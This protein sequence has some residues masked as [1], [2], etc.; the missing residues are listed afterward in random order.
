MLSAIKNF[1]YTAKPDE[2][3]MTETSFS[4]SVKNDTPFFRNT[5]FLKFARD[6][7]LDHRNS[8]KRDSA[9]NRLLLNTNLVERSE[10]TDKDSDVKNYEHTITLLF[11]TP[12][13]PSESDADV[14]ESDI[15]DA[16]D[17]WR[18]THLLTFEMENFGSMI[19]AFIEAYG[20]EPQLGL[21]SDFVSF[22][23]YLFVH[24]QRV[25]E[26]NFETSISYFN[27]MTFSERNRNN[28]KMYSKLYD[29]HFNVSSGLDRDICIEALQSIIEFCNINSTPS[30]FSQMYNVLSH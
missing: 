19:T 18:R 21:D 24:N 23:R 7:L 8:L 11:S 1:M 28:S 25:I 2:V 3:E 26:S 27:W 29:H 9:Y 20:S 14:N 13:S 12:E 16:N 17:E 6:Y 22:A 30:Y 4:S 15:E 5:K 10:I